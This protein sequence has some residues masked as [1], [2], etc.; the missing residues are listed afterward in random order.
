MSFE[1]S[2]WAIGEALSQILRTSFVNLPALE[3]S[4]LIE[5]GH[6]KVGAKNIDLKQAIYDLIPE[7]PDDEVKGFI[8]DCLF[9]M[10]M[11]GKSKNL[12]DVL[13]LSM[14]RADQPILVIG[15]SGSGKSHLTT[16]IEK[17]DT[18]LIQASRK[19]ENSKL[20][21]G[22]SEYAFPIINI[23]G[24]KSHCPRAWRGLRRRFLNNTPK[25]IVNV[26]AEGYL[27]SGDT[28]LPYGHRYQ[29]DTEKSTSIYRAEV[30]EKSMQDYRQHCKDEETKCL[31]DLCE[32]LPSYDE[33]AAKNKRISKIITVVNKCDLWGTLNSKAE[34]DL[35]PSEHYYT[36]SKYARCIEELQAKSACENSKPQHI[37]LPLCSSEGFHLRSQSIALSA[38]EK[39][40]L[41]KV[42][43]TVL[44]TS[45]LGCKILTKKQRRANKR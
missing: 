45:W 31:S 24:L 20:K 5:T 42:A 18:A 44:V 13:R 9:N 7:E 4:G 11:L 25:L 12:A 36:G 39:Q 28:E 43:Q 14:R 16:N 15:A 1:L 34:F 38:A 2:G 32:R 10:Y 33:Y 6:T 26:A 3:K 22:K 19:I 35:K 17:G 40:I 23:P 27:Q 8:D 41:N 37:V 21:E 30:H 29:L